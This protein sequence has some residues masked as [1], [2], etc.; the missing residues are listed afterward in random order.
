LSTAKTFTTC[1]R[2]QERKKKKKKKNFLQPF[3]PYLAH[4]DIKADLNIEYTQGAHCSRRTYRPIIASIC[5][6]APAVKIFGAIKP[7][8]AVYFK[9]K[10]APDGH[11]RKEEEEEEEKRRAR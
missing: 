10:R 9:R 7:L 1:L 11:N 2:R 6:C 8:D 5:P 3:G 4:Y